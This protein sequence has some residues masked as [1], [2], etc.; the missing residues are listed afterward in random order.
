MRSLLERIKQYYV[1]RAS[2]FTR[3]F[4][5]HASDNDIKVLMCT[6]DQAQQQHLRSECLF[7]LKSLHT[8]HIAARFNHACLRASVM[9]VF[10]YVCLRHGMDILTVIVLTPDVTSG[11]VL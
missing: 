5:A 3:N 8:R 1:P 7:F 9:K 10:V 2:M 4:D 11:F 6:F